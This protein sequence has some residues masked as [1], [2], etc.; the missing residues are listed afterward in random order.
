MEIIIRQ[1]NLEKLMECKG[2]ILTGRG[3]VVYT[4]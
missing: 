4:G 1:S 2:G 3:R